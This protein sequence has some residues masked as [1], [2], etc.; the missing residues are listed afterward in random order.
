M[1]QQVLN[2]DKAVMER[3]DPV[4]LPFDPHNGVKLRV[5]LGRIITDEAGRA[6]GVEF[7]DGTDGPNTLDRE[8][9]TPYPQSGSGGA[10]LLLPE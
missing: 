3:V 5:P 8:P 9:R 1:L 6:T 10:E 2:K 7:F 4:D